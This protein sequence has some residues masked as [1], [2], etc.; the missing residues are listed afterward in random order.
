MI[1]KQAHTPAGHTQA[2]LLS[3]PQ[4]LWLV[5]TLI[6]GLALVLRL[7]H[8]YFAQHNPTFY[9]PTLDEATHL[10]WAQ[11]LVRDQ[12]IDRT[13]FFRA[14][15][16]PYFLALWLS[17]FDHSLFAVKLIQCILGS[18]SCGMLCISAARLFNRAT[19][20]IVGIW[21]ASYWLFIYYDAL[22]LVEG[23]LLFWLAALLVVATQSPTL[24]IRHALLIGI[25]SLLCVYTRPN[26]ILCIPLL[27]IWLWQRS[28]PSLKW[29]NLLLCCSIIVGGLSLYGARNHLLFGYFEILPTQGG[30]N[31]YIGNHLGAN[32]REAVAA[33]V[34]VPPDYGQEFKD[35]PFYQDNVWYS[36]NYATYQAQGKQPNQ[37][38]V[39]QFWYHKAWQDINADIP[40]WLALTGKKFYYLL[41]AHEI[42][43]TDELHE[44]WRRY[45]GPLHLI[46]WPAF[47]IIVTLFVL[48]IYFT[49]RRWRE[50]WPLWTITAVYGV[51]VILFF[52]NHRFRLP[53]VP[54][55]GM[56][57]AYA[58]T[59]LWQQWRCRSLSAMQWG[60]IAVITI[61]CLIISYGRAFSVSDT[62]Y[63]PFA[64][65]LGNTHMKEKR[66]EDAVR[67]FERA[68]TRKPIPIYL[69]ALAFAQIKLSQ[70]DDAMH[71]LKNALTLNSKDAQTLHLIGL[72]Y[73]NINNKTEALEW[74][75]RVEQ[76]DA[77][78]A[79]TR[80]WFR[81]GVMLDATG[82]NNDAQ[83]AFARAA[84]T[85]EQA[86][87]H[88]TVDPDDLF[89]LGI[90][91][92][93]QHKLPQARQTLERALAMD[94]ND[95][96]KH[97][98]L[99]Q[100]L[101]DLN[102]KDLAAQHEKEGQRLLDQKRKPNP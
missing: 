33:S 50:L 45:A 19:A 57:S 90:T 86:L 20:W 58:L 52:V 32:G 82:A 18:L 72:V 55:M 80:F 8:L 14:P 13:E 6:S 93:M 61:V 102:E 29:K 62:D 26:F 7:V 91:Y 35:Y 75:R 16:Y 31:F 54:L 88:S 49:W 83:R 46:E 97:F 3:Q 60:A 5:A 38:E 69:N 17:L 76:A 47:G 39:S 66:Y 79:D 15:V 1:L 53:M 43:S 65:N 74:Y 84:S 98:I 9:T 41:N 77:N 12:F 67:E 81:Y 25:L 42:P 59:H 56:M 4:P 100:V 21:A 99:A 92:S 2:T 34:N 95:P 10:T 70:Y 78:F 40:A 23:L 27:I 28:L 51:S 22:L 85:M 64:F 71:T 94:I 73:Y 68:A 30:I 89:L 87:Q 24:R 44:N 96:D 101:H 48:S 63:S 36:Y 37:A 11:H